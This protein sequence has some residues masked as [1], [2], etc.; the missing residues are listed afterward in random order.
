MP[1]LATDLGGKM[2]VA[3]QIFLFAMLRAHFSTS[4][5]PFESYAAIQKVA[6]SVRRMSWGRQ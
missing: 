2:E 6:Q 3:P 4:Q 1:H 5:I